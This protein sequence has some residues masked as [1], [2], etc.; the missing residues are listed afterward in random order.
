MRVSIQIKEHLDQS[1]QQWLEGLQIVH[2]ENDTSW[3]R[4]TLP[5][6]AALYGVLNKLDRLHLTLLSLECSETPHNVQ[7]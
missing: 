1:W 2:E 6:Q 7:E 5:D 4:G 3:L